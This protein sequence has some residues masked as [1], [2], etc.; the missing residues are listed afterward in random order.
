MKRLFVAMMALAAIALIPH[1]VSAADGEA[2]LK[3]EPVDI[4]C[5]MTGKSG[6]GHAA[7]AKSCAE[8]GNPIGFV[9]KDGDKS[10]LYLVVGHGKAAKDIMAPLMGKQVTAKGTVKDLDGM[11]VFEVSEAS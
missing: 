1:F 2:T 7:C 5:Y 10:Q 6:E 9:V 8:K 4:N 11:K 3:G